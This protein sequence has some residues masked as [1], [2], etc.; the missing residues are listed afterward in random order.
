MSTVE[1]ISIALTP[2]LASLVRSAVDN[3]MINTEYTLR[4]KHGHFFERS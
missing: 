1:K 4:L 2:D 3:G